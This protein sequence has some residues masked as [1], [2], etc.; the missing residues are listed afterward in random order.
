MTNHCIE[1]GRELGSLEKVYETADGTLI[2]RHCYEEYYTICD[3]CGDIVRCTNTIETNDNG[4]V[5]RL[6]IERHF[7]EC[8]ECHEYFLTSNT[9]IINGYIYCD[10]C[11]PSEE[12]ENYIHSY[13]YTPSNLRY[14]DINSVKKFDE[15]HENKRYFGIE[16]EVENT[17]NNK[18]N[19]TTLKNITE[20]YGKW[21]WLKRDGSLDLTGV[22]VVTHPMSYKFFMKNY[23][24]LR[25]E[26]FN[27]GY[28]GDTGNCGLHVHVNRES[29]RKPDDNE[30]EEYANIAKLLIIMD[31]IWDDIV[32]RV[33]RRTSSSRNRWAERNSYSSESLRHNL[34]IEA[35]Y[36]KKSEVKS[37]II[38]ETKSYQRH[39]GRYHAVNLTNSKTVEFR[40]FNS[41][42]KKRS[43]IASLQFIDVIC[44]MA[45]NLDMFE[46]QKITKEAVFNYIIDNFGDYTDLIKY[47][48]SRNIFYEYNDESDKILKSEKSSEFKKFMIDHK[49]KVKMFIES[50]YEIEQINEYYNS[51]LFNLNSTL[52]NI[53]FNYGGMFGYSNVVEKSLFDRFFEM[54][55]STIKP[56]KNTNYV[57]V[58]FNKETFDEFFE[59]YCKKSDMYKLEWGMHEPEPFCNID[60]FN[61][62]FKDIIEPDNIKLVFIFK[63][64]VMLTKNISV[65]IT[66][67]DDIDEILTGVIDFTT[68][69][70][71]DY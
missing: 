60:L 46:I 20:N 8:S 48:I 51:S 69:D 64:D 33:D 42:L 34:K 45:C 22:E 5:C 65:L 27:G 54:L 28:R 39:N 59:E 53:L 57:L 63:N 66:F 38:N 9:T 1:C 47:M 55:V 56:Q 31:K 58:K 61:S 68:E 14:H 26:L 15:N 7:V 35:Y 67:Y 50:E 71:N 25:I 13:D 37:K 6:C 4:T 11:S 12:P 44:D 19:I 70:L 49:K 21:V 30:D 3:Y 41:T 17:K 16:L 18:H 10:Y 52:N 62:S 36:A 2:C 24:K 43:V 29:F 32:C 40:F 23:N